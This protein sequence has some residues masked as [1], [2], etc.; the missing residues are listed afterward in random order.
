MK[1]RETLIRLKKF[2][3]DEKRRR[4]AQIEAMLAD[5]ERM[6]HDLEREVAN[7]E[8]RAGISDP[9]HFAYPT[10]ARAAR[11]RRENILG[12][13]AEMKTQLE[14]AKAQLEIAFEE[15]K[16]VEILQDREQAAERAEQERR[17]QME[18]D[19]IGSRMRMRA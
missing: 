16:K 18:M 1:S 2:Q 17:E 11:T 14:G 15:L 3:V 5:F 7:E 4:V 8:R 13:V 12:S 9:A 6:A 19:R 10:Y